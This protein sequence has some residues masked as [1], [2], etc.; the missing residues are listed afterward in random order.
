MELWIKIG[1]IVTICLLLLNIYLQERYNSDLEKNIKDLKIRL[2]ILEEDSKT[3]ERLERQAEEIYEILQSFKD[4]VERPLL[5]A[6]FTP[7]E[8]FILKQNFLKDHHILAPVYTHFKETYPDLHKKYERY[9]NDGGR[10]IESLSAKYEQN[11]DSEK[12]G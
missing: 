1:F 11:L 2:E 10:S 4:P 3:L 8:I 9:L 12:K 5:L 6:G 7:H